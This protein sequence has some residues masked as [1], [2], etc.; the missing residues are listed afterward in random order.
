MP[1]HSDLSSI[2]NSSQTMVLLPPENRLAIY[3][4]ASG[5]KPHSDAAG[6]PETLH[7]YL[8]SLNGSGTKDGLNAS[9]L[10]EGLTDTDS[11]TV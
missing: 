11:P 4:S 6:I 8:V 9:N 10:G 3:S 1:L 7:E 5:S 2:D